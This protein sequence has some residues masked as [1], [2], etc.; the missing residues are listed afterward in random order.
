MYNSDT[1]T[2]SGTP[3]DLA[4]V[5][6]CDVAEFA[7]ALEE[8]TRT[9]TACHSNRNGVVTLVSRRLERAHKERKSAGLRQQKLREKRKCH[10]NVTSAYASASDSASGKGGVGEREV[11][12]P[13]LPPGFPPTV[14]DAL[15]QCEMVAVPK[16]FVMQAWA[17]AHGRGGEDAKGRP[18]RNFPSTVL[19]EFGLERN[20]LGEKQAIQAA[21]SGNSGD[22]RPGESAKDYNARI[23]AASL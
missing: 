11:E 13:P 5:L 4:R 9:N 20:R 3:A 1:F 7:S 21:T 23:L 19:W 14:D 8:L 16:E 10:A 6:R 12:P 15:L 2:L 22:R 17:K 18:I